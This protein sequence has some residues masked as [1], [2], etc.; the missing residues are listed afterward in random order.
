M[1]LRASS[2]D[3]EFIQQE[4]TLQD[5]TYQV[6]PVKESL[7]VPREAETQSRC[8]SPTGLKEANSPGA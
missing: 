7:G 4:M 6:D 5:L 3:F 2:L 1:Q 8:V